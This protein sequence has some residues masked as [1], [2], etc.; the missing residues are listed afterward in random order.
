MA[1]LS[2][3]IVAGTIPARGRKLGNEVDVYAGV[4]SQF[5]PARGRKLA[6]GHCV[7]VT[8]HFNFSP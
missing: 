7:D 5:I 4:A 2:W 1:Y 3:L 6:V 8:L